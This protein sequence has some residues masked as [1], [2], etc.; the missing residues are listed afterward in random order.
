MGIK[1][2]VKSPIS[3]ISVNSI[4]SRSKDKPRIIWYQNDQLVELYK[5]WEDRVQ[6]GTVPMDSL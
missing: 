4:L 5:F 3:I 1:L 2:L 6:S